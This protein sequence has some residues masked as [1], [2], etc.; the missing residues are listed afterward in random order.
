[1]GEFGLSE[2]RSERFP[3]F[4]VPT[5]GRWVL[6][7]PVTLLRDLT[8][9]AQSSPAF[10]SH[11]TAADWSTRPHFEQESSVITHVLQVEKKKKNDMHDVVEILSTV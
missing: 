9:G 2:R 6:E 3:V 11:F 10:S 1:M 4:P 8:Q 5:F 7:C